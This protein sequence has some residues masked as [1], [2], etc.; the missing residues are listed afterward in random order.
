MFARTS[1]AGIIPDE[2]DVN[3]VNSHRMKVGDYEPALR[4]FQDVIMRYPDHAIAYYMLMNCAMQLFFQKT[5]GN[6]EW[7]GYVEEFELI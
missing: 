4:A 2:L 6:P 7:E 5:D 3:F 1:G